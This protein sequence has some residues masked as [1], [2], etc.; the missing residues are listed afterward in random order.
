MSGSLITRSRATVLVAAGAIALSMASAGGA[1]AAPSAQKCTIKSYTPAKF[2]VGATD[3]QRE[4][5]VK[6]RGCT[7][8]NWRVD[9]LFSDGKL[10][11]ASKAKPLT[12]FLPTG[13]KN[14][15]A[16]TYQVRVTVKSTDNVVTRKKFKFSL[17]RQTTF[18]QSINVEPA[19]E[20]DGDDFEVTGQLTRANWGPEPSF[21]GY[22][23]RTVQVQFRANGSNQFVNL[24][25][26]KTDAEGQVDATV[27]APAPGSFRLAFAGNAASSPSV[28][29][30]DE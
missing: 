5:K 12:T 30:A 10:V 7:K 18:D 14:A 28:S 13:L 22:A 2:T 8:K 3:V 26:V 15:D 23:N 25:A 20:S 4:F 27:T 21:S 19:Q 11:L 6:T 24:Q 29:A 16:G 1:Q 9:L 17:L